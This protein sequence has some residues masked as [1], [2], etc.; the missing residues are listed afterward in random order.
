MSNCGLIAYF[1]F[2]TRPGLGGFGRRYSPSM[3][4]GDGRKE[5]R[6]APNSIFVSHPLTMI[7]TGTAKAAFDSAT[8][9]I[10]VQPV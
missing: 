1:P 10:L 2:F 3:P 9:E 6:I 8:P 5:G 4:L 7:I